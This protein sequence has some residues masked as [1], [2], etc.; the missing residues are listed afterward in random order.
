MG[1][2]TVA[3]VTVVLG[4]LLPLLNPEAFQ[5]LSVP[6]TWG[7]ELHHSCAGTLLA[8]VLSVEQ[9]PVLPV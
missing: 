1:Q 8:L 4:T 5:S 6:Q 7:P 2:H 9:L 3:G